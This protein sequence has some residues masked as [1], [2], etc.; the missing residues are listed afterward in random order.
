MMP[1]SFRRATMLLNHSATA[2]PAVM[3]MMSSVHTM[4]RRMILPLRHF[5]AR[6]E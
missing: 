5:R 3:S 4:L 2:L 6:S 1:A